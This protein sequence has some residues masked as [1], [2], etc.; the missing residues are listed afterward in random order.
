MI[1]D[2]IVEEIH[3]VRRW[4]WEECDGD[5]AKHAAKLK[6]IAAAPAC[7]LAT[8]ESRRKELQKSRGG[9]PQRS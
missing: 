6:E 2:P 9:P 7:R 3:E 1:R 4:L 8:L 5:F